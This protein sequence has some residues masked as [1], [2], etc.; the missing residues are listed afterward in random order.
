MIRGL[1]PNKL[2]PL[3]RQGYSLSESDYLCLFL[4]VIV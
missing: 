3:P 4:L 2:L 1:Q